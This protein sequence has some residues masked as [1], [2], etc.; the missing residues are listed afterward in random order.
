M[1]DKQTSHITAP[2]R[3]LVLLM[4]RTLSGGRLEKNTA[5]HFRS[6]T[7]YFGIS[8]IRQDLSPGEN[9]LTALLKSFANRIPYYDS[10]LYG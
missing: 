9:T 5:F 6:A 8:T 1:G 2:T 3:S 10:T 7:T 4:C